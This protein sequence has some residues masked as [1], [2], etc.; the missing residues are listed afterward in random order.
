MKPVFSAAHGVYSQPLF[1]HWLV[2]GASNSGG[3]VLRHYFNQSQLTAMTPLLQPEQPTGLDYYPLL[4]A[5]ER[6][7]VNDSTL[8]P[9]LAPRPGDDVV[10]FQG[11]LEGMAAIEQRGYQLLAELGAPFPTHVVTIGGGAANSAWQQIRTQY[12]HIPI[13]RAAQQQAA[14]GAALLAKSGYEAQHGY[15]H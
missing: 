2:G 7:P 15:N 10:F 13:D 9:L 5:G 1:D 11:M 3:A 14:F 4:A 12:L 8:P 6:F